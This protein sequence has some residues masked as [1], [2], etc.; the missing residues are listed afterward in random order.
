MHRTNKLLKVRASLMTAQLICG[1][2]F[3]DEA[4]LL[5]RSIDTFVEANVTAEKLQDILNQDRSRRNSTKG[6][7]ASGKV[8]INQE[9]NL[10]EK[11]KLG[12]ELLNGKQTAIAAA[13]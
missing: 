3:P 13:A 7:I 10:T 4:K 11:I 5:L 1:S 12:N 9:Q 6:M 8:E 2:K